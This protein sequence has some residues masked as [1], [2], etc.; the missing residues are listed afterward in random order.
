MATKTKKAAGIKGSG[1]SKR[2][3]IPKKPPVP[4][5]VATTAA[6]AIGRT[7][8][9]AIAAATT[10]ASAGTEADLERLCEATESV[11]E[12]LRDIDPDTLPAD[13]KEEYWRDRHIARTAWEHAENAAFENLVDQQKQ[14]LPP[15]TASNAKLAKD[16][17]TTA[18]VIGVLNVVSAALGILA[19][20]ITLLA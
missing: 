19:S 2:T 18:T 20:V 5:S 12:R 14:E 9:A 8:D 4:Q 15:V 17:E 10:T 16:V 3:G 6:Q 13:K 7:R 11:Y 1:Q